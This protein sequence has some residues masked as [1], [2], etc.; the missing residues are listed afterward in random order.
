VN[1]SSIVD[2]KSKDREVLVYPK[3]LGAVEITIED[4][5]IP[6]SQPVM[7]RILV[8]DIERL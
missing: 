4:F 1:D 7:T 6:D 5:E 2:F 3:N 8:S